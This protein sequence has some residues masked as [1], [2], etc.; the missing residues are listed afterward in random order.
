MVLF[1]ACVGRGSPIGQASAW[2]VYALSWLE[3]GSGFPTQQ[4]HYPNIMTARCL[5]TLIHARC[6]TVPC[7]APHSPLNSPSGPHTP[8]DTSTA[9]GWASPAAVATLSGLS[10]PASSQ[11]CRASWAGTL[12]F[13]QSRAWPEP[14]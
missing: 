8:L 3:H 9:D 13:R 4:Q 1:Q 10:P 5:T 12:R 2:R 11:P 7:A 14:P 6:A